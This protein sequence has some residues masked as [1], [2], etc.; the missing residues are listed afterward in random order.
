[1]G[2]EA[3]TYVATASVPPGDAEFAARVERHRRRRPGQWLTVEAPVALPAVVREIEGPVL[4]DALGP[5]VAN[6]MAAAGGRPDVDGLVDALLARRGD[7]VIVSEEV[8]LGVHPATE[9]GRR[10]ADLL[11]EVNRRVS[12]VADSVLLVVAGRVVELPASRSARGMFRIPAHSTRRTSG[13]RSA[14][15]FLTPLGRAA[16]PS[17]ATFAWFPLVG[18]LLGLLLGFLWAGS[19]ELF[20]A[21]A[22][23]AVV[24]VV[25][26]AL[27]GALHFDGLVDSADGLLPHLSRERRLE[28]MAEPAAGAFGIA[29]GAGVL[30]VR[31]AAL[32]G[33]AAE[34]EPSPL[35]LA[36]LWCLS[37]TSMVAAAHV[38]PYARGSG[39]ASAFAGGGRAHTFA[40]LAGVAGAAA[41]AAAD[42]PAF[43]G[44][45]AAG[46]LAA[47]AV[48]ALACRRVGGYTGDTLGAGGI[49]AET[50]GLLAAIAVV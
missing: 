19:D 46:A 38:L 2:V 37:R 27:T 16:T 10:F 7:V 47:A 3:V 34:T 17:A 35:L 8:G 41:L 42:D 40:A 5:W 22:G 50:A 29:A 13:A 26:L 20:G 32:A 15:A 23:A 48:A 18:A 4:V 33:F 25:D 31:A 12:D 24:V 28:V 14:L 30:V 1:M 9:V 6:T 11:G 49:L 44:A 36:A 21:L 39:L 43:L 45:V